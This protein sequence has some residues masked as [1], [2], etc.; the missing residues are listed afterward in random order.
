MATLR[1]SPTLS[2]IATLR[3]SPTLPAIATLG[4]SPTLLAVPTL[5]A[6]PALRAI[7]TLPAIHIPC[8]RG[9]DDR[10]VGLQELARD[11]DHVPMER[12]GAHVREAI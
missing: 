11:D 6:I 4:A 2:A 10:A 9:A 3:T 5:P 7:P 8:A 1:A 12:Y